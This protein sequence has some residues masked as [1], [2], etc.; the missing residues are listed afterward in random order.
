MVRTFNAMHDRTE[1]RNAKLRRTRSFSDGDTVWLHRPEG[2]NSVLSS[3]ADMCQHILSS[4]LPRF[5]IK[6]TRARRNRGTTYP[7]S[8]SLARPVGISTSTC[9]TSLKNDSSCLLILSSSLHI[10][11]HS[12]ILI[13]VNN[14]HPTRHS[15][16]ANCVAKAE[17][18]QDRVTTH[19]NHRTHTLAAIIK[20]CSRPL[21]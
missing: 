21:K 10:Y 3:I 1:R 9:L 5:M 16:R 8:P 2:L 7:N 6:G 15:R 13:H 19:T 20:L 12:L 17:C 11:I 18:S 14:K 4:T